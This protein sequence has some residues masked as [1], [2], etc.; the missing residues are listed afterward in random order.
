ME[1]A[2]PEG[3]AAAGKTPPFMNVLDDGWR[4]NDETPVPDAV[5]MGTDTRPRG[6]DRLGLPETDSRPI[7][8]RHLR[9]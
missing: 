3:G 2:I 4:C 7:S 1:L 5:V 6:L 9:A 8:A